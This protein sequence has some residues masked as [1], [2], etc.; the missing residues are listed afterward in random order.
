MD[1]YAKLF[2]FFR[3]C[4]PLKNLMSIAG[5][6]EI[7]QNIILPVGA[8]EAYQIAERID[9]LG[10]YEADITPFPS[11]YEDFQINCYRWYDTKDTTTGETNVNVLTY[12]E[13]CDVCKWIEEQN[14]LMNF[15]DIGEQIVLME[16]TPFVPQIR[17]IDPDTNIVGYFVTVRL[18]YV[19]RRKGRTIMYEKL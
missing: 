17:Y 19:N 1:K 13:V 11:V 12:E 2:E 14:D 4:E 15:P 7:D 16:C 6:I 3:Q 10:D 8:S 9:T 5:T 18:Q